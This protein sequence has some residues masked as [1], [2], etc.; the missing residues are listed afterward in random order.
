MMESRD[1][2]IPKEF[3]PTSSYGKILCVYLSNIIIKII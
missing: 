1:G 2:Y 3:L